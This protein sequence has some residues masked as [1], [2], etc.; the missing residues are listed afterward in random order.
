M[1]GSPIMNKNVLKPQVAPNSSS[2][3]SNLPTMMVKQRTQVMTKSSGIG[4]GVFN[5][6]ASSSSKPQKH[7]HSFMRT[8]KAPREDEQ[9]LEE[10]SSLSI[11]KTIITQ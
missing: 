6:M 2:F 4:S 1:M 3:Q 7:D 9:L 11:D 8:E 5:R 10:D